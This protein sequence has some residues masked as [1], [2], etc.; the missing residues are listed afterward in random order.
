[1]GLFLS[2]KSSVGNDLEIGDG[3]RRFQWLEKENGPEAGPFPL[4]F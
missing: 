4:V 3:G 2:M 1:M